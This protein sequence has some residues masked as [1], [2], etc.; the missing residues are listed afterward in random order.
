MSHTTTVG[1]D[2]VMADLQD[3]VVNEILDDLG[4]KI[5]EPAAVGLTDNI[6]RGF[7]GKDKVSIDRVILVPEDQAG[8]YGVDAHLS[9]EQR[10][11]LNIPEDAGGYKIVGLKEGAP[12][13]GQKGPGKLQ[14]VVD[15][16]QVG[17]RERIEGSIAGGVAYRQ[18]GAAI[19]QLPGPQR[20]AGV[21]QLPAIRQQIVQAIRSDSDNS[22]SSVGAGAS[23]TAASPAAAG[24]TVAA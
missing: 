22:R 12:A 17:L 7:Y 15:E 5:V 11:T 9:D 23:S 24:S 18:V 14:I 4:W 3:Q 1:I 19:A 13:K 16:A 8:R 10:K 21:R 20:Q 2:C 6:Y